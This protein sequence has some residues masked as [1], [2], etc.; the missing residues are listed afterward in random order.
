MILSADSRQEILMKLYHPLAPN[1]SADPP[2]NT[3]AQIRFFSFSEGTY[4]SRRLGRREE[5][6][7]RACFTI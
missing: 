2:E 1:L 7:R 6:W 3:G 5:L 4:S